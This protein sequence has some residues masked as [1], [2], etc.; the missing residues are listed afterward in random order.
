MADHESGRACAAAEDQH[1]DPAKRRALY[2]CAI[3]TLPGWPRHE[4]SGE[5]SQWLIHAMILGSVAN[6]STGRDR[7]ARPGSLHAA[8]GPI[9]CG[10]RGVPPAVHMM[11]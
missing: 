5:H 1:L 2:C 8:S 11:I 10:F 3:S 7:F 4:R 6:S 9:G